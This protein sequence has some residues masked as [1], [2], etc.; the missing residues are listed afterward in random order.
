MDDQE[1]VFSLAI[2]V[3]NWNLRERIAR[4][5][6]DHGI[7]IYR[8]LWEIMRLRFGKGKLEPLYYSKYEL[9]KPGLTREYKSQFVSIKTGK[10]LNRKLS[11]K[12]VAKHNCFID[13]KLLS[14]LAFSAAGFRFAKTLAMYH[15]TR[16]AGSLRAI[17]RADELKPFLT[18]QVGYP[19]FGKPLKGSRGV[20]TIR[21]EGLSPDKDHLI[22]TDGREIRV[23]RF[24][25]AVVDGYSDGYLFQEFIEQHPDVSRLT[26][27]AVGTVRVVTLMQDGG[28]EPLYAIW[29]IPGPGA[30]AD[31]DSASWKIKVG[32]STALIDLQSGKIVKVRAG[33]NRVFDQPLEGMQLP[34]WQDVVKT[35]CDGHA[36]T[37]DHGIL[38]WDIALG[39][40]GPVIVECNTSPLHTIYQLITMQPLLGPALKPEIDRALARVSAEKKRLEALEI[41]AVKRNVTT[42]VHAAMAGQRKPK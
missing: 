19:L 5:Q 38:G 36:L 20:G 15:P 31:N 6:A 2:P 14:S 17:D 13:D 33:V 10:A 42:K 40:D 41:E 27:T 9:Y 24:C 28:P 16:K 7:S 22:I 32:A 11:P 4:V 8:Q 23:S 39:T 3:E 1:P 30:M 21:I 26:P 35:V 18:E 29:K 12:G 37:P 25:Q 34:F